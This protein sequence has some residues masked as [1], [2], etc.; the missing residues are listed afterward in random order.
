MIMADVALRRTLLLPQC[1]MLCFPSLCSVYYYCLCF[2]C[3]ANSESGEWLPRAVQ[4]AAAESLLL[5]LRGGASTQWLHC[6]SVRVCGVFV[7]VHAFSDSIACACVVC[8]CMRALTVLVCGVFV[9]VRA[10]THW[11]HSVSVRVWCIC[12]YACTQW[13]ALLQH[14]SIPFAC[15]GSGDPVRVLHLYT[16]NTLDI[17][18]AFIAE[19]YVQLAATSST[20]LCSSLTALR[21]LTAT[22]V[23]C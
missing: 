16:T 2:G 15:V 21:L 17:F 20:V 7:C 11:L 5:I 23:L 10:C 9:S 8:V 18:E 14:F 1:K 6:V 19:A 22:T 3:N 12:V 13:P 4:P